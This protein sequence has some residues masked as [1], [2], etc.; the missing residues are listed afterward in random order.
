MCGIKQAI[1]NPNLFL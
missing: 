1:F